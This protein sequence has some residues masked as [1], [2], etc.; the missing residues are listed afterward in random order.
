MQ[1]QNSNHNPNQLINFL[2]KFFSDSIEILLCILMMWLSENSFQLDVSSSWKTMCM[3]FQSVQ[4]E[5][6]GFFYS[7]VRPLIIPFKII[8]IKKLLFHSSVPP[9]I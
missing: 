9:L 7:C 6:V 3:T 2:N 1:V 8:F 4:R 5:K